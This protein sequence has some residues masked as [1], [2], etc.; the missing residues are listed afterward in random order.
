MNVDPMN[1]FVDYIKQRSGLTSAE[2]GLISS[3][4][5]I[6]KVEKEVLLVTAGERYKKL[7]FVLEGILRIYII[8]QKG[9][10]VVK[11]FVEPNCFFAEFESFN[12]NETSKINVGAVTDCVLCTLTKSDSD[13]LVSKFPKWENLMKAG[14]MEA[15]SEMFGKREFLLLGDSIDQYKYFVKHHPLLA[16]HVPLKYIASYLR[17]T[18]SSLSRIR[19][20]VK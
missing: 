5:S 20:Q 13:E 3:Y 18:Q 16:K 2:V 7:V 4:F 15:M 19:R 14:A 11:N 17:I 12:K 8:D 1:H 6:E 9:E 10:E